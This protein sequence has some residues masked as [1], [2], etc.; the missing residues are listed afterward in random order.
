MGE[1]SWSVTREVGWVTVG[2]QGGFFLVGLRW[3]SRVKGRK[4]GGGGAECTVVF[5]LVGIVGMIVS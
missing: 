3:G 2:R 1:W 5:V 4:E